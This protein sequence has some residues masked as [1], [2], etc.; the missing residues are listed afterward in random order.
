[1]GR[2]IFRRKQV[3]QNG[4]IGGVDV[5]VYRIPETN[6]WRI[7]PDLLSENCWVYI[8]SEGEFKSFQRLKI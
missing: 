2:P 4:T 5:Y 8:T 1:M 7:G 6:R 3:S